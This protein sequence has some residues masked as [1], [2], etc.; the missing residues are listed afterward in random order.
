MLRDMGRYTRV[1]IV[2]AVTAILLFSVTVYLL[3]YHPN[4]LPPVGGLG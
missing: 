1:E 3:I 2:L 4:L